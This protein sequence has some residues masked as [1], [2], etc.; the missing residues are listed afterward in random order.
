MIQAPVM[1][2]RLEPLISAGPNHN[3]VTKHNLCL[4]SFNPC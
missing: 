4:Y 2:K 3:M 1:I